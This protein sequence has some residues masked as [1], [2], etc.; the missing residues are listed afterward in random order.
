MLYF[1]DMYTSMS[2][3]TW[4]LVKHV[5][6]ENYVT[7]TLWYNAAYHIFLDDDAKVNNAVSS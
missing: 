1:Q 5:P 6:T 3:S 4:I 2:A 7:H